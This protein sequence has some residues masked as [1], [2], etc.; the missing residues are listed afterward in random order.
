MIIGI[1]IIALAVFAYL[2]ISG[3]GIFNTNIHYYGFYPDVGGLTVGTPVVVRGVSVGHV[4]DLE[5]K[6]DAGIK[7]VFEIDKGVEIPNGSTAWLES[8]GINGG[9]GIVIDMG[10]GPGFL[11]DG[12]VIATKRDTGLIDKLNYKSGVYLRSGRAMLTIFDTTIKGFNNI[13]NAGLLHDILNGVFYLNK[14]TGKF[15]ALSGKLKGY[16]ITIDKGLI[17]IDTTSANLAA[18][19]GDINKAIHNA[20]TMMAGLS[21]KHFKE[22]L[23][24]LKNNIKSIGNSIHKLNENK[25]LNN[26]AAYASGNASIDSAKGG[27]NDIR[28]HPSA[29]WMAIF[30]KNRKK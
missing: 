15:E 4:S 26:K 3:S 6:K 7:A 23:D 13:L 30:G 19:N 2:Y 21:N 9:Q 11:P 1:A 27:I 10:K 18:K 20:D 24:T 22:S 5:L 8:A 14:Q 25:M 16:S 29:H 17:T 28:E 12:A